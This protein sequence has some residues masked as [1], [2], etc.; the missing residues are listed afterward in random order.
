MT[1][2][3]KRADRMAD[4]QAMIDG[5][6]QFFA[7]NAKLTVGSTP[8][9]PAAIVAVFQARIDSA[10]A[11]IAAEATAKGAVAAD[12]NE[13]ATTAKFVRTFRRFVQASFEETPETLAIFHLTA[14]KVAKVDVATKA[15][16]KVKSKATRA[17]RGTVGEKAKLKISGE[18]PTTG[19]PGAAATPEA[20]AASPAPQAP[21]A[22]P[23]A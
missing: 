8:M 21:A 7:K 19:T 6:T 10:K 9:L 13:L 3:K 18:T 20:A 22:K 23:T 17:A 12:R 2:P 4:D 14:P 5:I 16:A 15:Q 1:N 11:V